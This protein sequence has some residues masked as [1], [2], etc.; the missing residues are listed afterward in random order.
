MLG[1]QDLT[2]C[3]VSFNSGPWLDLNIQLAGALNPSCNIEWI[4]AE[5]SPENST[6]KLQPKVRNVSL[7]G[8]APPVNRPYAEASYH[9]AAGLQLTLKKV[10]SRFLLVLDPDFYII[11]PNWVNEIINY[12]EQNDVSILG[13]PWHPSRS[14]KIRYFPCAHCVFFDLSKVS[15]ETLDFTPDYDSNASWVNQKPSKK[16]IAQKVK[17][18]IFLEKRKKIGTSR[19]TGWRIFDLYFDASKIK[20][21]C[22]N[23]A[24]NPSFL[25]KVKDLFYPDNMS[26]IPKK[27]GYFFDSDFN[28]FGWESDGLKNWEKFFWK[29]KPFGFHVRCFPLR[30]EDDVQGVFERNR[31]YVVDIVD[32]LLGSDHGGGL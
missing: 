13:V 9:H 2:V 20:V 15:L 6:E 23:P 27:K 32:K 1:Q 28:K 4:V 31:Q 30:K 10:R 12:M 21:E 24:F 26:F 8:G 11:K 18:K 17:A 29:G 22:L 3:S 19:D 16:S 14:R 7:L 5:N 25:E